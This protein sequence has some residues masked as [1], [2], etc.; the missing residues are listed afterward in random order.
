MQGAMTSSATYAGPSALEASC[1][2]AQQRVVT[3]CNAQ[4]QGWQ[5]KED[6]VVV[7]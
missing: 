1:E 3:K 5:H 6:K 2:Q 4:Q 7:D